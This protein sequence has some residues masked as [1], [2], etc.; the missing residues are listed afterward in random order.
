MP[1]SVNG[2]QS[3]ILLLDVDMKLFSISDSSVG[4]N[5]SVGTWS[6]SR[7]RLVALGVYNRFLQELVYICCSV[8]QSFLV[9]LVKRVGRMMTCGLYSKWAHTFFLKIT[10]NSLSPNFR[11]SSVGT[12]EVV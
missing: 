7:P 4:R 9:L 1:T 2:G 6:K 5:G 10:P 11:N 12:V 3:W 8:T